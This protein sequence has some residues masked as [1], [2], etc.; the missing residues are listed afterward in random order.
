MRRVTTG[1]GVAAATVAV[2]IGGAACASTSNVHT[3]AGTAPSTSP[4]GVVPTGV[5]SVTAAP[6]GSST[7]SG[8]P[9]LPIVP[10]GPAATAARGTP[11]PA[12]KQAVAHVDGQA[13]TCPTDPFTTGGGPDRA[14]LP[15]GFTIKTVVRCETVLR[16]YGDLGEWSVQLAEVADAPSDGLAQLATELRKPSEPTPSGIACPAI[17]MVLPW[18]AVIDD[19]GKVVRPSLPTDK[20]GLPLPG[21][22]KALSTLDFT[23]VDAVR[24]AQTRAPESIKTG[25][26]Q[27]WKDMVALEGAKHPGGVTGASVGDLASSPSSVLVCLYQAGPV[28]GGLRAGELIKGVTV[29]GD[30]AAALASEA[31]ST[32]PLSAGCGD[33]GRFAVIGGAAYV[34]LGGCNRVLTSDG[35]LGAASASLI[36]QLKAALGLS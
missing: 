10:S 31:A 27:Q 17:A 1:V 30:A 23:A 5:A 4:A 14:P 26:D 36:A 8:G 11:P 35:R 6:P 2:M 7:G 15:S 29:S 22:G 24:V 9:G 34:E 3:G 20:C 18:F 28:D 12:G 21:A 32:G 16:A 33:A 25:C 19:H 13:V